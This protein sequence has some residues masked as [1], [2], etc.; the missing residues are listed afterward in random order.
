MGILIPANAPFDIL[1]SYT[2]S[3]NPGRVVSITIKLHS[4]HE[5]ITI[6][7]TY[8]PVTRAER[9]TFI[10]KLKVHGDNVIWG[11]DH[12]VVLDPLVDK[13]SLSPNSKTDSPDSLAIR[14]KIAEEGLCDIW[15]A[16]YPN[17][18]TLTYVRKVAKEDGSH[19][20]TGSRLDYFLVSGKIRS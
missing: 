1:S 7:N 2:D 14:C 4:N 13:I 5:T 8:A 6:I 20:F 16:T 11:G 17:K 10:N 9:T 18:R 3:T 19:K 15:R 12:N